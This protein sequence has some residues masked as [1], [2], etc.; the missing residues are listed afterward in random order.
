MSL[1]PVIA[2][3]PPPLVAIVEDDSSL[4][5]A[6]GFALEQEGLQIRAY[7]S[8]EAFLGALPAADCLVIDHFLPGMSGLELIARLRD[9]ELTAPALLITSPPSRLL[10][11]RARA[12]GVAVVEKPLLGD[13]LLDAIRGLL[14][15]DPETSEWER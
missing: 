9:R 1:A 4:L 15:A 2:A 8:A 10:A 7:P 11:D 6:L 5:A 13:T 14:G 3:P 12:M